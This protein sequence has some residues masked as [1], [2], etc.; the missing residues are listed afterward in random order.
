MK[1]KIIA[2]LCSIFM[3]FSISSC[4]FT[5]DETLE[6]STLTTK[7]LDDGTTMVMIT[8]T[9]ETLE[10]VVFYIP[11][12][13]EGEKGETGN[14]IKEVLYEYDENG[15]YIVTIKFTDETVEP[16]VFNLKNGISIEGVTTTT[17]EETGKVYMTVNFSNG[18]SSETIE[19][20]RGEKGKDGSVIVNYG[21]TP[22]EETG[23]QT[24]FFIF[25]TGEIVNVEIPAPQ[26]GEDGRG[27]AAIVGYEDDNLY[28]ITFYFT[29]DSEPETVEFTKPQQPNTWL[30]IS[31][32]KGPDS[33]LGKNGDYCYDTVANAIYH[34]DGGSWV[35][36]VDFDD[37]ETTHTIK[38]DVNA[39][40][41]Y[42]VDGFG[43]SSSYELTRGSTFYA[44]TKETGRLMPVAA[45]PGYKFIGW[46]SSSEL[47][48]N[49]GQF[50]DLTPIYSD[51]TLYAQ[52]SEIN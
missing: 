49:S 16:L 13:D 39:D 48:V 46:Y 2:F 32:G 31:S 10:P 1:N 43:F 14:G 4:S 5:A 35:L 21:V 24:L 40:D 19:L 47:T 51:M 52:W 6:I 44:Y 20:P 50:T 42:L 41:A 37:V 7:L 45:R 11:K 3:I 8:Y 23:G 34:K 12:G 29:D 18:T 36:L 17:D 26:K 15:D 9:D 33:S 27:I 22:N 38:F 25:S 28:Y 30:T